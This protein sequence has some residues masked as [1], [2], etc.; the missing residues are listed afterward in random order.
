LNLPGLKE[1]L[2]REGRN[3]WIYRKRRRGFIFK[4]FF[5]P[6]FKEAM[7]SKQDCEMFY[8]FGV[9][10]ARVMWCDSHSI[11]R[12]SKGIYETESGKAKKKEETCVLTEIISIICRNL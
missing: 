2:D 6:G 3:G 10:Y 12:I 9:V 4:P 1:L 7:V 11:S 8:L 5:F